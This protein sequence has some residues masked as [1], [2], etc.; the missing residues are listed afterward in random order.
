MNDSGPYAAEQKQLEA[1]HKDKAQ[2]EELIRSILGAKDKTNERKVASLLI[3]A[4]AYDK[5][6]KF[7]PSCLVYDAILSLDPKH[8]RA[9]TRRGRAR[10]NCGM[11][12]AAVEDYT[13]ARQLAP[14]DQDIQRELEEAHAKLAA[15]KKQNSA[16][17]SSSSAKMQEAK[18]KIQRI[19][20]SP[21]SPKE[22][23]ADLNNATCGLDKTNDSAVAILYYD[24]MLSSGLGDKTQL[25]YIYS[26]R[27][28]V[29]LELGNFEQAVSDFKSSLQLLPGG[30]Y[31]AEQGLAKAR[32][33]MS[34]Q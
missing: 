16:A 18:A 31:C 30:N 10:L 26:T 1:A 5:E 13:K 20:S 24:A 34:D 27:G 4:I 22:K 33:K 23:F 8:V 25:P 29:H 15:T 12:A 6:N 14:D 21:K 17:V 2:A 3:K 19:L 9:L 11:L 32:A 7:I 28:D